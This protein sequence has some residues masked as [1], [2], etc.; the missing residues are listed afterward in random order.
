MCKW[1]LQITLNWKSGVGV[2]G[3]GEQLT[4]KNKPISKKYVKKKKS[5][6]IQ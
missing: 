1:C 5:K 6:L 2:G 3:G 4:D